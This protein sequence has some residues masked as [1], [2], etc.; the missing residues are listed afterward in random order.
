MARWSFFTAG[1]FVS[2]TM[3]YFPST[4]WS[5][6]RVG[7]VRGAGGQGLGNALHAHEAHA[8]L[9][10]HGERR[11]PA[12][13]GDRNAV[14]QAYPEEALAFLGLD[15]P[16]VDQNQRHE[17]LKKFEP[18]RHRGTEKKDFLQEKA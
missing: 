9:A 12:V 17:N 3:S 10:H 6:G 11:V 2:T 18:Q 14:V 7:H 8:A 5:G 1:L 16:V 4:F 15:L 13:V